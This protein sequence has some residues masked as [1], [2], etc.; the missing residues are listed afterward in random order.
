MLITPAITFRTATPADAGSLAAL[1][2]RTFREAF[3]ADN[4]PDDMDAYCAESFAIDRITAELQN[5]A[6]LV[7]LATS[8]SELVAYALLQ[9]GPA[10][11]CV[12]G[13][14]PIEIV[15]F[16]V[17]SRWHGSG[18]AAALMAET[19][20]AA[21][22]RGAATLYLGVWERNHRALAFYRKHGFRKVGAKTFVL[23]SDPQTDEVME[24]PVG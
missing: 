11:E 8:G 2:E 13:P 14:S 21:R 9:D 16:Y 18:V 3:A 10:P 1:A 6:C 12:I 4:T 23:G 15:R 7:V 20:A 17:D 24:R 19:Q 22:R 5:P